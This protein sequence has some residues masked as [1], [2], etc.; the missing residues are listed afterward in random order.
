[1]SLVDVL[2]AHQ[3]SDCMCR[4]LGLIEG[5]H[6]GIRRVEPVER[7]DR[8]RKGGGEQRQHDRESAREAQ[9]SFR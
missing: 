5:G 4:V 8:E 2:F 9:C 1:M 3:R 6:L 7:V